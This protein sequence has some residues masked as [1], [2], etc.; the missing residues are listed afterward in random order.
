MGL[1][2]KTIQA[3]HASALGGHTGIKELPSCSPGLVSNL[4]YTILFR[5]AL[6]VN[7]KKHEHCKTPRMLQPLEIPKGAWQEISM[8]F[9][10]GLPK[11]WL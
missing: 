9:T 8:G 2:N 7:R 1:Q 6:S 3:L 4:Q 11:S 5:N 10:E